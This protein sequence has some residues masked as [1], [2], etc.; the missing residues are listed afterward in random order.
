MKEPP[1]GYMSDIQGKINVFTANLHPLILL[2]GIIKGF[3]DTTVSV[4]GLLESV[5]VSAFFP[6]VRCICEVH[7]F[8]V[9]TICCLCVGVVG[10]GKGVITVDSF[11]KLVWPALTGFALNCVCVCVCGCVWMCGWTRVRC[12]CLYCA[13][14]GQGWVEVTRRCSLGLHNTTNSGTYWIHTVIG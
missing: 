14:E 1:P 13:K 2:L 6:Y 10:I 12:E 3:S 4:F 9:Y 8:G 7:M 5:P 11:D